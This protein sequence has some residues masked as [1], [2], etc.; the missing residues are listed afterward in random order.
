[1]HQNN[2]S[3]SHGEKKGGVK[4]I[5]RFEIA[6]VAQ[7]DF[8]LKSFWAKMSPKNHQTSQNREK[9]KPE[10]AK[11]WVQPKWKQALKSGVCPKLLNPSF[12][13]FVLL[14]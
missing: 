3:V 7:I 6:S 11:K 10:A 8:L 4:E 1:M 2:K 12:P 14:R 5:V 9:K 13:V